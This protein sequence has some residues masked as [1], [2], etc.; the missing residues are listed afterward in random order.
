MGTSRWGRVAFRPRRLGLILLTFAVLACP[1]AAEAGPTGGAVAPSYPSGPPV[2][3]PTGGASVPAAAP[4]TPTPKK[5]KHRRKHHKPPTPPR[6][7]G[8]GASDIPSS[9]LKLYHAAAQAHNIDWRVLA[10]IGKNESDHGRTTLPGVSSGVNFAGCCA[11]PMQ[12]CIKASC[13][14]VWQ[15]YAV[16]ANGDGSASVYDPADAIYAAAALVHDLQT[17]LGPH[18]DLLL[19]GYNAGPGNVIH[20]GGVPP[21]A[22]TKAYVKNGLAYIAALNP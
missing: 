2:A 18:P 21:F 7:D 22:E 10:A 11:G 14:N 3:G 13:G 16:D 6:N 5:K 4:T 12:M 15:A 17:M 19:A 20:Y 8:P 1:A 9:Y